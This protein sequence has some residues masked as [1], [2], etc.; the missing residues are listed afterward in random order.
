MSRFSIK[1]KMRSTNLKNQPV[2]TILRGIILWVS[3][4]LSTIIV[5]SLILIIFPFIIPF[6]KERHSLHHL[7]NYWGLTIKLLNPW[8]HFH[9][10]GKENLAKNNEAAIYVANH[11]SQVDILALFLINMRFRWLSKASLFK[12]PFFGWAMTAIGYVPVERGDKESRERC[13]KIAARHL[14][15]NTPMLFFPEGTR[16]ENGELRPFKN[17]AFRLAIAMNL[18]IIPITINGCNELLPKGSILPSSAHIT[19]H[20]HPKI[21]PENLSAEELMTKVRNVIQEQLD[22][23]K[24]EEEKDQK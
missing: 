24:K 14:K 5:S 2:R 13:M 8:W 9:I 10:L 7:A 1:R 3:T 18:P 11:Q 19:I 15:N 22:A 12:I 21:S 20:I 6:D 4:T 17:G 16:S 23:N